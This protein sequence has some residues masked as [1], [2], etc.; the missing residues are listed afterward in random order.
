MLSILSLLPIYG[1]ATLFRIYLKRNISVSIFFSITAIITLLFI[2]AISGVLEIGFYLLFYGGIVIFV[3]MSFLYKKE[4]FKVLFSVPFVIFT[5]AS[6]L[7][8]YFMKDAHFF[9]WDEYSHWGA[10]IKYIY[11]T[12]SLY[13]LNTTAAHL[14]YLPGISLWDYFVIKLFSY[15]EGSVYF[16]YF[17]VIFSSTLM[18]YEKLTWKD[19][20]WIVFVF[21]VQVVVFAD[22]GHWFSS[23]YVDHVVGAMTIGLILSY[24]SDKYR[25]KELF[26]F[27]FPL[28]SIVLVKEVGLYFGLTVLG[29]IYLDI[30]YKQYQDKKETFLSLIK[31][32]KYTFMVLALLFLI[33]FGVLQFWAHYQA[34]KG[35]APSRQTLSAVAKNIFSSQHLFDNKTE[36]QIKKNLNTVLLYQQLHQ[37]KVSLN[38]NEFSLNIMKSY[39]KKIKLTTVGIF[40]FAF[41]LLFLRYLVSKEDRWRILLVGSYF[42]FTT[43]FYIFF[44]LYQSYFVAFGSD[45]LRVPSFVRYAN[46]AI[47]PLMF[48]L[49]TTFLPVFNRQKDQKKLFI[50]GTAF[51]LCLMFIT[52]P[53]LPP[54]YSQLHNRARTIIDTMSYK[55]RKKVPAKAKLFV[56]FMVHNNGSLNNMLAY[57]LLPIHTKVSK[58]NFEKK[59]FLE[60]LQIY[61]KYQYIWFAQF[62][63]KIINK[64][65][66]I[67]R[68]KKG[69]TPYVLYKIIKNNNTISF[70]PIL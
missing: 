59:S 62:D 39:K 65:R 24:I 27:I 8:L 1:F 56:I 29:F 35:I 32:M 51:V 30:F 11:Y 64:N 3:I 18:M 41:V 17:L 47:L 37:E 60:M 57:S 12:N 15:Q 55:I 68:V 53:Y 40:I 9:F 34:S 63:Q 45:A 49:F 25:Q 36:I 70:K 44:I 54:L 61:R 2:F 42:F 4:F 67:L 26:L 52:K 31:E 6:L 38:Y 33:M 46:I 7:Y 48:L 5:I 43:A 66:K 69:K 13:D 10:F 22:F 14:N 23:I 58:F 28:V 21:V 50:L 19:T 16:A 20:Y